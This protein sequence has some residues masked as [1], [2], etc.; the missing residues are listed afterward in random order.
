MTRVVCAVEYDGAGFC[1]WQRQ[2][3]APSVQ[4]RVEQALSKVANQAV[5]VVC[6]GRTD[7]GVHATWQV[8]HFDTDAER[9]PRSWVLGA[10][11]NLPRSVRLLS[12]QPVDGRFHAR[13]S[14]LSR[15]YHYVIL[16][17]QVRTA[18]LSQRVSWHYHPLDA[19]LMQQAAELLHGE[20]DF[21]SFRTVACQ[22]HN[23]VRTIQRLA[24][25]R[26]GDFLYLD[27]QANAFLHHMV[28]N[29]AGV[30]MTVGSGKRPVAWVSEILALRDRTRGGVTAPA[31]GLYLVGVEYPQIFGIASTGVIPIY[32]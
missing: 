15:S 6:A 2:D 3:H 18:L 9:S 30:L 17:R 29:I 21:S 10:N 28:R 27:I 24:I 26:S 7:T 4:A 16:N 32:G 11:A 13:F 25:R 22:A 14:A 31:S 5:K 19:G 8:I 12:A 1:G 23:P 20:H